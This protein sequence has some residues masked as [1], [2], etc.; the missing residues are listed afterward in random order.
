VRG[1]WQIRSTY[2]RIIASIG[3]AAYPLHA[4]NCV[5]LLSA[6]GGALR[7]ARSAK[8][9]RIGIA[10]IPGTRLLGAEGI[11]DAVER[12]AAF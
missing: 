11:Q 1:I 12:V 8:N 10:D 7:T 9:A 3:I 2:R 6:A 4:A 5:E